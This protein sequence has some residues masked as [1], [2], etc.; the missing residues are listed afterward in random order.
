MNNAERDRF[1]LAHVSTDLVLAFFSIAEKFAAISHGGRLTIPPM[2]GY[3]TPQMQGAAHAEGASGYSGDPHARV[4][5]F[6]KHQAWPALALDFMVVDAQGHLIV[7][8]EDPTYRWAG[9]E[10]EARGF[11]WGGFFH[12]P[13]WDHVELRGLQPN[14][15]M[16]AAGYAEYLRGTP[17][18][19]TA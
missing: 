10:F 4:S 14:A 6:S 8:G 5:S 17:R 7:K 15:T 13:D 1:R 11:K 12:R 18:G 3:R 9:D 2:G 19:S 16:V